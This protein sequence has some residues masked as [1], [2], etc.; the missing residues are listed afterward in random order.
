MSSSVLHFKYLLHV[1]H[2]F[3]HLKKKNNYNLWPITTPFAFVKH[4]SFFP[5][6]QTL[7]Q[8]LTLALLS[9]LL[10]C[11]RQHCTNNTVYTSRWKIRIITSNPNFHSLGSITIRNL[12]WEKKKK[13]LELRGRP[14]FGQPPIHPV[15]TNKTSLEPMLLR[16]FK[17]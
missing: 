8:K 14:L 2:P 7:A 11:V 16:I 3:F 12:L 13:I 5:G 9:F 10:D 4:A 1:T 17:C 15:H 6:P